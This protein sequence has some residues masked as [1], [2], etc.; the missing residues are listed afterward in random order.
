MRAAVILFPGSNADAEMIHTLRN[1]VGVPTDVVWHKQTALPPDTDLVA[2]PGGFSYGDYLR[3][4]ALAKTS[5]IVS[6]VR[7]H[8]E[9]GGLT[10]GVCNGFQVLTETGLLPGALVLNEHRRFECRDIWLKT[11]ADGPFTSG[12]PDVLRIPIAHAD[13]RYHVDPEALAALQADK[14]IA[15]QYCSEGGKVSPE[16][17]P[18]GSVHEIA[19]VYGGENRN[20]LGLMPHPER[21][22]EP[23][24][25]SADG[26]VLFESAVRSLGARRTA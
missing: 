19:G 15:F 21:A 24:L 14:R 25:G 20:I 18:N 3:V 13:G 10:L 17:N 4:G 22:S 9:R 1:V 6:A 7:R 12:I 5:P 8:A 26:R 23:L 16:A 2:I 11:C